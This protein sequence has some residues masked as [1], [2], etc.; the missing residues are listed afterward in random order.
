MLIKGDMTLSVKIN[1][2]YEKESEI[3]PILKLLEPIRSGYRLKK[4]DKG[5]YRHVYMSE[6]EKRCTS[7]R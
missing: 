4:T 6:C 5:K 3:E 7:P 2:S 1:I